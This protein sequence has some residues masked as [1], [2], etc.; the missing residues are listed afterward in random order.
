A[1][2]LSTVDDLGVFLR[3]RLR[4][5]APTSAGFAAAACA[6][7]GDPEPV[8]R[9]W[10]D[11]L[12]ARTPSAALRA[13]SRAQGAAMLRTAV[14]IWCTPALRALTELGRPQQPLVLG[15]ACAAGGGSPTD[16][17]ALAVHHL[18]AGAC[19]AALRLLGLD[20][21]DVARL[22]ASLAELSRRVIEDSELDARLAVS[23]RDT[24]LL[25]AV[26]APLPD[27]LAAVHAQTEVTLF[28]S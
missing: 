23:T 16:A 15:A 1:T 12:S 9:A 8:W 26:G 25:P 4:T 14:R 3:G 22:H 5:V 2:G 18:V 21:L 10:D 11:A 28:A 20:P 17:A 13:A 19:S 6:L 24:D 27:I 7:A